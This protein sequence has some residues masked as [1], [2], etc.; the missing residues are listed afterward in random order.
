MKS[1]KKE[2]V[3]E[4]QITEYKDYI[5]LVHLP[6]N[7]GPDKAKEVRDQWNMLL[8]KWKANGTYVTSFVY[9]ND[10]YLV[11]GSE[12]SVT[13]ERVVSNHF[14][15]VSNMILRAANY[16]AALALA[17]SC[18][19]LEQGGMI[20]V[21]E[22]QPRPNANAQSGNSS[23]A[24]HKAI[25]RNLYEGILNTGKLE[26]LKEIISDEYT[27]VRGE[28]G[29]EGFAETVGSVRAGFPDIK[30]TVEDLIA[31]DDKVIVRWSWKGTNKGSFRGFAA[32]NKEVVDNAIAIYEFSGDKII[33]AW[34]HSDKL[35]FLQQ[36]GIIP[37]DVTIPVLQK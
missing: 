33:K 11:T 22:I 16:E 13:N 27:G 17:K 20:E 14:K 23:L 9:P 24:K 25:I 3:S 31:E 2:V 29:A 26:F 7:Y 8:E 15:L 37:Q 36:I 28:K 21:R 32:S 10:G 6:L 34:I 12:K 18:P 1:I 19:V 30:W 5:L 35:G 4:N